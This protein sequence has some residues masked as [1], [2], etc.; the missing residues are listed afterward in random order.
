MQ[1]VPFEAMPESEKVL[2]PGA[3]PGE[4]P[5][6]VNAKQARRILIMRQR[7]HQKTLAL[8]KQGA[9]IDPRMVL[10]MRSVQTGKKDAIRQRVAL[11][12]KRING[13]FVK[14]KTELRLTNRLNEPYSSD[15][16]ETYE[17]EPD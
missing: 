16:S 17:P 7:K 13:L 2:I 1:D 6:L 8:M 10:K 5:M 14:K 11:G 4:P 12:R 9:S 15:T 3:L